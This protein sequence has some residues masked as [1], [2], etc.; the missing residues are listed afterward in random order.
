MSGW[1]RKRSRRVPNGPLRRH[2]REHHGYR[3]RGIAPAARA[4]FG[5]P[6]GELVRAGRC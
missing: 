1:S 3:Q 4:L 5:L 6:A 2:V